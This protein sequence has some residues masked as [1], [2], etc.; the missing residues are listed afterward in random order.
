[1]ADVNSEQISELLNKRGFNR[2]IE[3]YDKID[4]IGSIIIKV[5]PITIIILR[6]AYCVFYYPRTFQFFIKHPITESL[7]L[8][9]ELGVYFYIAIGIFLV[10][11]IICL[12]A[13]R[14]IATQIAKVY[15]KTYSDLGID[16][17]NLNL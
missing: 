7:S 9:K 3:R 17:P 14:I 2:L 6:L 8:L 12:I 15:Y 16:A 13:R 5:I 4:N 11:G 1:M 10:G